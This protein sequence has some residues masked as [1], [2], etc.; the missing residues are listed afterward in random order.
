MSDDFK[1]SGGSPWGSPPGGGG[2]NG[3]DCSSPHYCSDCE[4]CEGNCCPNFC[5]GFYYYYNRSCS[6]G[7]CLGAT[8]DYCPDGCDEDGCL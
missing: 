3:A 2:G 1:Q 4:G 5:S 6:D 7:F 8:S